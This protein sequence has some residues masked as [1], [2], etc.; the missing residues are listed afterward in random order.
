MVISKALLLAQHCRRPL[1]GDGAGRAMQS[2]LL[3]GLTSVAGP[4]YLVAAG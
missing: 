1:C 2:T 3:P 4:T